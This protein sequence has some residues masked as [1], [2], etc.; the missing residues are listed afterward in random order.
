[1][2][3]CYNVDKPRKYI[4]QKIPDTKT[5]L[6]DAIFMKSIETEILVVASSLEEEGMKNNLKGI[7]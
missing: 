6:H 7:A 1:M 3:T 4:K 5:M 2:I